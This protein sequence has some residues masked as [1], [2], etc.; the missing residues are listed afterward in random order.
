MNPYTLSQFTNDK[1]IRTFQYQTILIK[2]HPT[3]TLKNL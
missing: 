3:P 2:L 1:S